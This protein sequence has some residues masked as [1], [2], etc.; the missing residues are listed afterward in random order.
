MITFYYINKLALHAYPFL[1]GTY[2]FAYNRYKYVPN[3]PTTSYHVRTYIF[4]LFIKNCSNFRQKY[5]LKSFIKFDFYTFK[6]ILR[7]IHK[8]YSKKTPKKYHHV[9]KRA[10]KKDTI[11]NK[12][13]E[14]TKLLYKHALKTYRR[15]SINPNNYKFYI[16]T[17]IYQN[18]YNYLDVTLTSLKNKH[19]F[20]KI[21]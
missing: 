8:I 3:G 14:F 17:I 12:P 19:K 2:F 16:N 6:G 10:K 13:E 15:L 11:R 21:N 9:L 20:F 7:T 18:I 5:K 1:H 4:Y